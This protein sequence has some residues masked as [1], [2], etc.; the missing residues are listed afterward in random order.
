[1]SRISNLQSDYSPFIISESERKASRWVAGNISD[2]AFLQTDTR[3]F[4][5]ILQTGRRTELASLNPVN[6]VKGSYIYAANSNIQGNVARTSLGL[7]LFPEDYIDQHYQIIYSSNR[8]RVY[9]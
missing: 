6:L 7:I 1:M 9:H 8:A 2:G 4:L 3:G 5:A